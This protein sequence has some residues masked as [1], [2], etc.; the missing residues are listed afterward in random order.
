MDPKVFVHT[1][2]IGP[3]GYNNHARDF[4]R[5]LSKYL[6]LKINNFTV[7]NSWDGLSDTPHDNED[8]IND[9]DKKLLINQWLWNGN[10]ELQKH[11]IYSE[12]ENDVETDIDL[13]LAGSNHHL[14]YHDYNKPKIAY[15]VWE[16]TLQDEG[17]FNKLKE[18]DQIWVP[19]KWQ[20][21]CT[22]KQ[23]INKDKIK[24]VPEG[25]DV[26]T[27]KPIENKKRGEKLQFLILGRWEY[28]K[29]TT[30]MIQSFVEVFKDIN[31]VELVL[32]VDNKFSRDGFNSTE[33]R[34]NHYGIN[35]DKLKILSFL[36]REDYVNLIRNTDVFLSC[37]RSE[38]W[39]L[40][41]IEAM[42]CGIPSIYSNCS[43][44][45][46]FAKGKGLP[47]NVIGE[48]KDDL[49]IGNY[50]E[51]DIKDL[52]VQLL[53]VY[54]NY[55]KHLDKAI[56]DSILIHRD[57]NWDTVALK[58]YKYLK[59]FKNMIDIKEFNWGN[60]NDWFKRTITD[61][62]WNKQ[63]YERYFTV[64]KG[65]V[66]FDVGASIGDFAYKIKNN[67]PSH[68]YCVEPSLPMINTLKKN[69]RD[70][71]HTIIPHC[72]GEGEWTIDDDFGDNGEKNTTIVEGKSFM[73]IIKDYGIEKI[74][75][76]KT[77][78]EGGEYNIFSP[79]NL[80]WI[81]ENVG[82]ITG[83]W[84]LRTPELKEKFRQF[85]DTYLKEF[86][87]IYLMSVDG[88]TD[89]KWDLWNEHFIEYYNEF[90]LYIDNR[91][92]TFECPP[93]QESLTKNF[94][95]EIYNEREY[96]RFGI[97]VKPGDI[98]LDAGGNVGI[99]TQYAIDRG[100]SK[101]V[102]YESDEPHFECYNK[103]VN[104]NKVNCTLGYVGYGEDKYDINKILEHHQIS[105][106]DFAKIDIE[107]SE[108][109]LLL[110]ID[111]ED[112]KKVNKWAIEFHP[113]YY[114]KETHPQEKADKLWDLLKILD[115]F[116]VNGFRV[117]YENIH[118]GWDVVHLFAEKEY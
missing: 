48:V 111:N 27:F 32:V 17:F 73:D 35:S 67:E 100:A 53:E 60:S 36:S 108:F 89:I 18:F 50:Y 54:S 14:F 52:K 62:I 61:E 103:N 102:A 75:F 19:S 3:T 117:K 43:G 12:F 30:E 9:L 74:D 79:E 96:D 86:D 15:N 64:E 8:Y 105:L 5:H 93:G 4:F 45:L 81:K 41:L 38:G 34:L 56:Q 65:D 88:V 1:T 90:I 110:N 42:S 107:G 31:D 37:S 26:K 25:V 112:L 20:A 7:G 58:G 101:V 85:R 57:F 118:K 113:H 84:H 69:I 46:E 40:P 66:V 59:Q 55:Q 72:I 21:K 71:D 33:E 51:P 11:P 91:K 80:G 47:V 22:V 116:S 78:C 115:K 109:D 114:N 6:K 94:Q 28:R 87:N 63:I 77:D 70:V 44:Q 82:K 2:Y 92:L 13:I 95:K 99:F 16:S 98:V 29:Y 104:N 23:G 97:A 39:N 49:G 68:I 83:E 24:V 10:K 76:L 106:I